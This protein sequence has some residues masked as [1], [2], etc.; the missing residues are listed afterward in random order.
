M[1]VRCQHHQITSLYPGALARAA[2]EN[3]N[4]SQIYISFSAHEDHEF[5]GCNE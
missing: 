5:I 3:E 1:S 4:E 2:A